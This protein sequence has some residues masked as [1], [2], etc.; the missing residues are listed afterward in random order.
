MPHTTPAEV[1]DAA[2]RA[3]ANQGPDGW[4]AHAHDDVTLE[5]PFAP[6]GRPAR[7]EGKP[8]VE[9]YLHAV[10]G[11]VE[12]TDVDVRHV[13]QSADPASAVIEWTAR[14]R[15]KATGAPYRMDYAV[16]VTLVDGLIAGYREYWNPLTLLTLEGDR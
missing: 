10:P 6:E 7:V 1:F 14:G 4:L 12:F 2:T 13:H 16:V 3:F 15:I 8:A 11:Q 9:Q 5:F